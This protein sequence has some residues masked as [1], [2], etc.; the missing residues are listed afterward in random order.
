MARLDWV[1]WRLRNWERWC[2]SMAGSGLG[3]ARQAAFLN[4]P[5]LSDRDV[6]IPIDE[7]EASITNDAIESFKVTRPHVYEV[8]QLV[9]R[10]GQGPT[11]T[12][13]RL[14]VQPRNVHALLEVGDRLIAQWLAERDEKQRLARAALE[15]SFTTCT[16]LCKFRQ[17]E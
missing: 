15:K 13:R 12:A 1:V 17:A 4:E 11:A 7:V 8:I 9:Y 6:R 5:S 3:F 10:F 2:V 16:K 14:E